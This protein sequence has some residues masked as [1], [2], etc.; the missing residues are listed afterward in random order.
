MG[1]W[2]TLCA[3][4][5]VAGMATSCTLIGGS[6]EA[7]RRP[8][9]SV[10][11]EDAFVDQVDDLCDPFGTADRKVTATNN[12]RK[13][14]RAIDRAIDAQEDFLK[15]ARK[16]EAP[17]ELAGPFGK[18]VKLLKEGTSL[19]HRVVLESK[20]LAQAVKEELELAQ[21]EVKLAKLARDMTLS[22]SC[23]PLG[24]QS[25][26]FRLFTAKT[27]KAC[28]ELYQRVN[29]SDVFDQSLASRT[30]A[31]SAL[32]ALLNFQERVIEIV[33][34]QRKGIDD[35][36]INKLLKVLKERAGVIQELIADFDNFDFPAYQADYKRFQDL[37]KKIRK[38]TDE[39]NLEGCLIVVPRS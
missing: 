22:S 3:L 29:K 18:Y 16:L 39:L 12:R 20:N 9:P 26:E 33:R 24:E 25:I 36:L 27:N 8:S 35:P 28:F 38:H 10:D 30:S 4:A 11:P 5:L 1:V 6:D 34:K 17:E 37:W 13:A 2:R 19:R 7:E 31:R 14:A 32:V 21:T 23:P 15:A